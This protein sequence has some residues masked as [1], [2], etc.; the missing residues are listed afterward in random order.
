MEN[1]HDNGPRIWGIVGNHDGIGEG[2]KAAGPSLG[3]IFPSNRLSV[4]PRERQERIRRRH[5]VQ[6]DSVSM[7]FGQKGP[8]DTV[9]LGRC[10]RL[11]R[12]QA[13]GQPCAGCQT[14]NFED[15]N[16]P[17]LPPGSLPKNDW[18]A[19]CIT[20]AISTPWMNG[21]ARRRRSSS[22]S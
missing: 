10:P 8:E 4:D 22:G 14:R 19:S 6:V 16:G 15:R 20:C 2:E 9:F 7:A 5:H 18:A 1:C 11:R 13:F 3:G 21:P 17:P 12:E